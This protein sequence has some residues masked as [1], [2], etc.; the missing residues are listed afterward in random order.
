MPAFDIRYLD[1]GRIASRR[2]EAADAA[3]ALAQLGLP[4]A[5]VVAVQA[6][7]AATPDTPLLGHRARF[8]L[9]LFSRELGVLLGAGIPLL[10]ALTALRE[11]EAAPAVA[12]ALDGVI[13]HLRIGEPFS[14]AV[15]A[16][17]RHFDGLFVAV[18]AAAE[19]TGQ[20]QEALASHA[21]YLAWVDMLRAR[22]VGASLYPL[23]LVLA[24]MAVVV[25]LLI[26]VV[27]RFAT[28]LD[29]MAGNIPPLSRA[30]L[31]T[32]R[33][34]GE[35]PALASALALALLAAP[36]LAWRVAAVREAVLDALWRLPAVGQRL[37]VLALARLYRTLNMLLAAGV[38][39][40]AALRT[41]RPVVAARLRPR[42]DAA[43][44]A[45]ARGERLSDAFEREGLATPVALRM[46]RVGEKSGAVGEMLG[47][48][49]AFHDEELERLSDW[50]TKLLNP[51]L[52]LL[53]G[54]VIGTVVVLLYLPIF[55]L[56]EQVQ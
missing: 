53:M 31:E 47:Q 22:L 37:R 33:V 36:A 42:V 48:A 25:F 20:L 24:S 28:M 43:L 44:A 45:V 13:E 21:R 46:L 51:L 2:I 19:R 23:L 4:A 49:A 1:A 12:A 6:G 14:A 18:I 55:Q 3:A 56:A 52:M 16:Q 39:A 8:P 11:K 7:A 54:G 32:G 5:R 27:P 35:H 29:G 40:P 50:V 10:E 17:P 9:A 41:A 26:F 15:A 30:L 38:P 34:A